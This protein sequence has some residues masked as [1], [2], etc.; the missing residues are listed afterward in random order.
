MPELNVP[1]DWAQLLE[2]EAPSTSKEVTSPMKNITSAETDDEDW[3][4]IEAPTVNK[5][6]TVEVNI[7]K[8]SDLTKKEETLLR[9]AINRA[10]REHVED[11]HKVRI[12]TA[13]KIN[14]L[15]LAS[16][17]VVYGSH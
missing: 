10:I 5:K 4:E 15:V 2:Q 7:E 6:R 8:K 14:L 12:I 13:L 11:I 17:H 1:R 3:E 16:L 9:Q